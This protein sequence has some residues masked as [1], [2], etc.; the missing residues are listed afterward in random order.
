M[1]SF[2]DPLSPSG[3]RALRGLLFERGNVFDR[4]PQQLVTDLLKDR[5]ALKPF[6]GDAESGASAGW[7]PDLSSDAWQDL[8]LLR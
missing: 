6:K 2:Q 7:V 1:T 5:H 3:G 8:D 4:T